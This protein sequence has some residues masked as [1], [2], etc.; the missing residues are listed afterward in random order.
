MMGLKQ[1]LLSWEGKSVHVIEAIYQQHRDSA[2]FLNDLFTFIAQTDLENGATWLLKRHLDAGATLQP[3]NIKAIYQTLPNLTHWEAKLH[4]LQCIPHMPIAETEKNVV[5][6]FLRKCLT[7]QNKF[8][9]AWTYH[10]FYELAV[11]YP[12]Y[13]GQVKDFFALAMRDEVASVKARIRNILK[14]GF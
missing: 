11:Q 7:E 5:E 6:R 8:I 12:E 10:G 2:D 13:R 1:A 9:R 14:Q 4:V 3:D